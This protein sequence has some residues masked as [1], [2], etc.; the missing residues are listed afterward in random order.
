MSKVTITE[1]DKIK[2]DYDMAQRRLLNARSPGSFKAAQIVR[3]KAA[4]AMRD[5][6]LTI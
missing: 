3:K 2:A 1:I 4:K 5:A 6:G